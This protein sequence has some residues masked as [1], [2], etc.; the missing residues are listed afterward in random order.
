MLKRDHVTV[1]EIASLYSQPSW[2]IRR[3]VDELN[4]EI[5]RA[6]QYRLVPR[7]LLGRIAVELERRGWL[8]AGDVAS[9]HVEPKAEDRQEAASP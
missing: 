5:P 2:R 3:C 8:P 4:V 7:S 1:G 9:D 6:G